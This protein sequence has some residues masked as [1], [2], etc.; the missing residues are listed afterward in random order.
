MIGTTF[1]I[2]YRKIKKPLTTDYIA[3][4][5]L[6][7]YL[8]GYIIGTSLIV[9][10]SSVFVKFTGELVQNSFF[11]TLENGFFSTALKDYLGN[12]CFFLVA[13]IFGTSILGC[14]FVPAVNV[15]KGIKDGLLI[16]FIYNTYSITGMG[17]SALIIIP[18]AVL[19]AFL[20]LLALRESICFSNKIFKN[21]LPRGSS[22]NLSNQFKIYSIRYLI[23]SL[24][25]ILPSILNFTLA[26]IFIKY[27]QL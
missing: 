1:K 20:T 23:L 12:F 26:K 27:F 5:I 24:T 7:S 19:T 16:S 6:I 17:L 13:F 9:S 11:N 14:I 10:Q 18:G 21:A 25:L 3:F 8:V 22:V 4:F 15:F 2:G